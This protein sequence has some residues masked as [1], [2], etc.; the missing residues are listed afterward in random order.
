MLTVFAGACSKK[1]PCPTPV[2]AEKQAKNK[3]KKAPKKQNAASEGDGTETADASAALSDDDATADESGEPAK[4][5]ITGSK[6][7]YSKNGLLQ[8]KKY[9]RL[10]SNPARKRSRHNSGILSIFSGK[11]KSAS[12]PKQRTN[13]EPA[14]Y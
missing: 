6:N 4:P 7:K 13:V 10:R 8:K 11:K 5:K 1:M 12:K 14:D 9:K 2:K 3:K